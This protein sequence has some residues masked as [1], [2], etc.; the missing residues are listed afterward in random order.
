MRALH[1]FRAAETSSSPSST[2]PY[3]RTMTDLRLQVLSLPSLDWAEGQGLESFYATRELIGGIISPGLGDI[4]F[5]RF[6]E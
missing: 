1:D 3:P 6:V 5:P 4:V 2:S